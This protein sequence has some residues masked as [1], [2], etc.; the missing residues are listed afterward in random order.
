MRCV[1]FGRNP[2]WVS[3]RCKAHCQ[4]RRYRTGEERGEDEV[5]GKD[6][7]MEFQ[8]HNQLDYNVP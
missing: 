3:G 2:F 4:E 6:I 5:V 8:I 7:N 1:P